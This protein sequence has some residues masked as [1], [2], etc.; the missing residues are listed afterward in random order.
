M[1]NIPADLRYTADHE[2]VKACGEGRRPDRH[3]RLRPGRARRHRLREPAQGRG[4]FR[5][6]R[7]VR[8]GRGGQ[9]GV[10]PLLA[11]W[12]AR[13][14]KS[15]ARSTPTPASSIAI[16]TT[17]GW[18]IRLR[19]KR[20]RQ[21]R[22][23]CSP[24]EAYKAQHRRVAGFLCHPSPSALRASCPGRVLSCLVPLFTS[25][26]HASHDRYRSPPARPPEPA[27]RSRRDPRAPD[28]LVR[29]DASEPLRLPPHRPAQGRRRPRW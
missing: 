1:S 10:R 29:G 14:R 15:T 7:R 27:R 5:R 9:G 25:W 16:P 18:M 20:S 28:A 3:H 2:Y 12:P 17:T 11:R 23:P 21:P 6:T 26:S 24:A 4:Q 8:R 13:S 19:I 22:P